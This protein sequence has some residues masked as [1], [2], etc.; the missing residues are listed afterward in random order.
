MNIKTI[1]MHRHGAILYDEHFDATV[2]LWLHTHKDRISIKDIKYS[3]SG[4]VKS[5]CIVYEEV[6]NHG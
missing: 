2:D 1:T 6:E 5:V 4:D 3:I